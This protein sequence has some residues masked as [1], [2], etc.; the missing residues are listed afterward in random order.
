MNLS[1]LQPAGALLTL[2]LQEKY[3]YGKEKNKIK[4]KRIGKYVA[5]LK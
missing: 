1:I 3:Y 5:V 2:H 4:L